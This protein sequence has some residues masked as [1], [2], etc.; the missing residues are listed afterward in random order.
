MA[1]RADDISSALAEFD[2]TSSAKAMYGGYATG[3]ARVPY[4]NFPALL[5]EGERVLTASENRSYTGGSGSVVISGNQFIVRQ[6][7]DIDA[8]AQA[9]LQRLRE[10]KMAGAY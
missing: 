5:H 10:A 2:Q 3:L 6:E 8:I 9:I 4:N 7:S 1:A